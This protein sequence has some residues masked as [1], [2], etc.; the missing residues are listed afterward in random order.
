MSS[1]SNSCQGISLK[2]TNANL[3]LADE[4]KSEDQQSGSSSG[5]LGYLSQVCR[6]L[7]PLCQSGDKRFN[8]ASCFLRVWKGLRA[9]PGSTA[10]I[11]L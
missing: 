10:A 1:L 9:S 3:M 11:K 4:E 6:D 7:Q 8:S 2:T 5:D